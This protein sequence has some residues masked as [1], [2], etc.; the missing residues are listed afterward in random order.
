MDQFITGKNTSGTV[1]G[2][3]SQQRQRNI[4]N[5]FQ[6]AFAQRQRSGLERSSTKGTEH[7]DYP[8]AVGP[9]KHISVP[10]QLILYQLSKNV[11]AKMIESSISQSAIGRGAGR[12]GQPSFGA[13]PVRA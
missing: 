8:G 2:R 4:T 1:T 3:D 12:P 6:T 10:K 13:L 7:P 11:D 5:S 9:K